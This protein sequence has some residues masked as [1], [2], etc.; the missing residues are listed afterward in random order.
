MYK[1][2][3]MTT[4]GDAKTLISQYLYANSFGEVIKIFAED[5]GFS[6]K[7][8]YSISKMD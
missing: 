7:Y 4:P 6:E 1:I 3:Y 2:L 5:F 8:I